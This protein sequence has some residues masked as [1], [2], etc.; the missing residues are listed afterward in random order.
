MLREA[1]APHGLNLIAATP[2]ERYDRSVAEISR[3]APIDPRARSIVVIGNGG[4]ALWNAL[5]AHATR[6]PGWWDRENTSDDFPRKVV[7]RDIG[8]AA[9]AAGAR[10]TIVYPFM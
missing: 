5:S 3:A 4:G 7:G 6:D 8:A 10:F 2:V 9:R 1:A